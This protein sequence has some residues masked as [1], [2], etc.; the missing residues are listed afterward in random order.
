[1]RVLF[2]YP[3]NYAGN[4]NG[5]TTWGINMIHILASVPNISL[6]V[7]YCGDTPPPVKCK[8]V[9]YKKSQCNES[10]TLLKYFDRVVNTYDYFIM[11]AAKILHNAQLYKYMMNSKFVRK[12]VVCAIGNYSFYQELS[13]KCFRIVSTSRYYNDYVT[14]KHSINE[15]L[16]YFL[17]ISSKFV[18]TPSKLNSKVI[19]FVYAGANRGKDV[20]LQNMIK[21]FLSIK[22]NGFSTVLH[23][24]TNSKNNEFKSLPS[25]VKIIRPISRGKLFRILPSYHFSYSIFNRPH[26]LF[27]ST[28]TIESLMNGVITIVNGYDACRDLLG[29]NYPFVSI[30]RLGADSNTLVNKYWNKTLY[31]QLITE[32]QERLKPFL[33]QSCTQA[34]TKALSPKES[35]N[36]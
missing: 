36:D 28:K 24:Y 13:N 7:L 35:S 5:S 12:L 33:L 9:T 16:Y 21:S 32:Q 22:V 14:R 29:E 10:I 6:D 3:V 23:I 1:M 4:C 31:T 8:N 17:P 20:L 11:R 27:Y 25:N 18:F 19:K 30:E 2:W 34:M 15:R 26:H